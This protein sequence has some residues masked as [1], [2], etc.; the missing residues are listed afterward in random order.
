MHSDHARQIYPGRGI[1]ISAVAVLFFIHAGC[2]AEQATL[3][4]CHASQL[5]I[6]EIATYF[7]GMSHGDS[8]Y[9]VVNTSK[10]RCRLLSAKLKIWGVGAH[11]QRLELHADGAPA[12]RTY[13]T[14]EPVDHGDHL[15]AEKL[16]W[17]GL[18]GSSA[19][20][21]PNQVERIR[22]VLP[23]ITGK[24]F[25]VSYSG[26]SSVIT[27]PD[28]PGVLVDYSTAIRQDF[29]N[30]PGAD[31]RFSGCRYPDAPEAG[32]KQIYFRKTLHCD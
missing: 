6:D 28:H 27:G 4:E 5:E 15:P 14:L 13:I 18:Q 30:S 21:T 8:A 2:H 10:Y 22:I 25:T 32:I 24:I 1:F 3:P 17:F 29:L 9:G 23:G 12:K 26:N 20:D 7:P 11:N 16:A 31:G 19:G